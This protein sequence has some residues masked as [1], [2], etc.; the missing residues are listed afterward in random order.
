M[1]LE[2]VKLLAA[3]RFHA[4]TDHQLSALGGLA[5]KAMSSWHA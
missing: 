4:I 1:K 2:R 5:R 3:Q